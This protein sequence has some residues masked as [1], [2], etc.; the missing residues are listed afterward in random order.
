MNFSGATSY[1]TMVMSDDTKFDKPF[2]ANTDITTFR[3]NSTVVAGWKGFSIHASPQQWEK[4]AA[5][6]LDC[7]A[8]ERE[9]SE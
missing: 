1:I 4:L 5:Y 2:V 6:C 8:A 7:A 9:A 3:E